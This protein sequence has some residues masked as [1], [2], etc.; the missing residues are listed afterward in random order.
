MSKDLVKAGQAYLAP[1]V[2]VAARESLPYVVFLSEKTTGFAQIVSTIQGAKVPDPILRSGDSFTRLQPLKCHFVRATQLWVERTKNQEAKA[3]SVLS[4]Q[5]KSYKEP[6][7][8]EILA[9]LLVYTPK[10]LVPA[11]ATFRKGLSKGAAL[12]CREL[13]AVSDKALIGEWIKRSDDHRV[14]AQI[15]FPF[16]R[17]TASITTQ[18]EPAKS[19][20]D[21]YPASVAV[22]R[23]TTAGDWKQ[24]QEYF[25]AN[26]FEGL[27]AVVAIHDQRVAAL[28][29][30]QG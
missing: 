7:K 11:T 6:Q 18:M 5:P 4:T 24:L 3:L 19:G 25:G 23:P 15:E 1:V 22:C 10:G 29:K 17:F 9:T 27:D 28:L 16:A 21:P 2:D 26:G 30:L 14:A 8:E 12:V 20:G 13:Q